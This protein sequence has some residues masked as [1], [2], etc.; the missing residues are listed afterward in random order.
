VTLLAQVL[1]VEQSIHTDIVVKTDKF[2]G[3]LYFML[4]RTRY[5]V[6]KQHTLSTVHNDPNLRADAL[7]DEFYLVSG[8]VRT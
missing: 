7:V 2:A 6:A 3:E 4:L 1:Y 5:S 8:G